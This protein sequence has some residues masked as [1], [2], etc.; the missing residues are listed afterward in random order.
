MRE[1]AR[2]SAFPR[3]LK[4][5]HGPDGPMRARSRLRDRPGDGK[6]SAQ[7]RGIPVERKPAR[8][9]HRHVEDFTDVPFAALKND[10][11]VPWRASR[12][13]FLVGLAPPFTKDFDVPPD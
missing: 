9:R 1:R 3:S 4:R 8:S 11:F 6:L 10:D 12:Q 2:E 13:A 5:N 7:H